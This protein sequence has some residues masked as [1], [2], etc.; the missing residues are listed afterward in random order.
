MSLPPPWTVEKL[1]TA[2]HTKA[3]T[4]M[5]ELAGRAKRERGT[6]VP[7][8]AK[9]AVCSVVDTCS[10]SGQ[11]TTSVTYGSRLAILVYQGSDPTPPYPALSD[12]AERQAL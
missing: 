12:P 9:L 2:L 11:G 5:W 4:A 6:Y 3:K 1:Q 7:Y 10:G 8:S